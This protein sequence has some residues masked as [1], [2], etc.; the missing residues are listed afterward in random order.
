MTTGRRALALANT[1]KF[2]GKLLFAYI[3]FGV[4]LMSFQDRLIF[5]P[6]RGGQVA[7]P[8][9]D[10]TLRAEDGPALHARYIEHPG[11]QYTLLYFHGNAGNLENRSELLELFADFGANVLALEYRGYG[12]SEGDP[13]EA[14][15]YLD[16]RAAYDWAVARVPAKKL[17]LLG[18][19]LGGGP[20]CELASTREVGG[21][22][23]LSAFTSVA[24]MAARSFPW[25]PVRWIVRTRF[26]N[27]AKIPKIRAPKLIIHSRTDE[28]VPF[29]MGPRLFAAAAEPKTS[30]WLD[31]AGHNETF[32]SQGQRVTKAVKAFLQ[33]LQ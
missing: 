5:F 31:R 27:L 30:L 11:A 7:G 3:V 12:Q 19:S 29:E 1:L 13:S 17:V 8:G 33:S 4:L 24:D 10:L 20:A 28:V 32:Y 2:T 18:E 16:A 6:T 21:V 22:I 25:L 26:D 15:L 23:L 14:G 9:V